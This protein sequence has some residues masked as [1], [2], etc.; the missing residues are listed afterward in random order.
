M[1]VHV[2]GQQR[3]P[4][5]VPR[6]VDLEALLAQRSRSGLPPPRK[7]G[8][9][10][11]DLRYRAAG[12][13]RLF[14]KARNDFAEK[15]LGWTADAQS[16]ML[17]DLSVAGTYNKLVTNVSTASPA[18]YTSNAHGFANGDTVVVLGVL[19]CLNANQLGLVA[20]QAANTFQ[21][22]TLEGIAVD[23]TAAGAYTAGGFAVNLSQ[24]QFVAGILGTRV[25]ADQTLVG[26]TSTKGIVNATS[27]ISWPTVPAGNPVQAIVF[28]DAAGGSDATNKVIAWQ[29]G[30]IRVVLARAA[31]AT[32]TTLT[33][34]P[35]RGQLWD[36]AIGPAPVLYWSDGRSSTL[37]AAA[38]Q[39][40]RQLTITAQA[41]GGVSVGSTAE[42]TVFGAGLPVTPS[43]GTISFTIGTILVVGTGI[44]QL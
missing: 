40:A 11:D 20:A 41:A 34:E 39:G 19:G 27:P 8:T 44:F 38:A 14:D 26:K 23:T 3:S 9:L 29:D 5:F 21:L 7:I 42:C 10:G 17:L 43:G 30:K 25:G 24:A 37:N 32:D 18:V 15:L 12:S 6:I 1:S 28:Y 2:F 13:G 35:L 31:I 36:G 22:T 16:A 33:I 4:L